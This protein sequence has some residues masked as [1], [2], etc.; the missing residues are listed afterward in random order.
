MTT[1]TESVTGIESVAPYNPKSFESLE[2]SEVIR[3]VVVD[4]VVGPSPSSPSR[5][6]VAARFCGSFEDLFDLLLLIEEDIVIGL[7][8]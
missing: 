1:E 4:D 6:D 2:G 8:G 3:V 7:V 5:L